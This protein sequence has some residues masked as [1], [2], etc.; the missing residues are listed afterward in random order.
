MTV[1]ILLLQGEWCSNRKLHG[2]ILA[3][4]RHAVPINNGIVPLKCREMMLSS[5][6]T[7]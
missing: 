4:L 7:V 1:C 6:P 2:A 5:L 3:L